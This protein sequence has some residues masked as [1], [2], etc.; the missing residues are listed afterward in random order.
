MNLGRQLSARDSSDFTTT[1]GDT[2]HSIIMRLAIVFV[3]NLSRAS[4]HRWMRLNKHTKIHTRLKRGPF[5]SSWVSAWRQLGSPG[6]ICK[7]PIHSKHQQ[8]AHVM[9]Y[10]NLYVFSLWRSEKL[11]HGSLYTIIYS[12]VWHRQSAMTMDDRELSLPLLLLIQS[13]SLLELQQIMLENY[14][15]GKI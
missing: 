8:S 12:I 13:I 1:C 9:L 7:L 6:R 4:P 11:R 5:Q 10:K 3:S 14:K 15:N 2:W